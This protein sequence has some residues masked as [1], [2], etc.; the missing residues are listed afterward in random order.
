MAPPAQDLGHQAA[1]GRAGRLRPAD[2]P[3]RRPLGMGPVRAGHVLREGR[4]LATSGQPTV[5]GHSFGFEVD[6]DD[7]RAEARLE[8]FT[9]QLVGH[10]VVVLGDLDVVVDRDPARLPL[11]Q[12]VALRRQGLQ[13]RPIELLVE[14]AAAGAE[15]LHRPAVELTQ[16][17]PDRLVEL[18]EAEKRLIAQGGQDPALGHQD[19]G[20]H[21]RLVAGLAHPGRDDHRP[22][23]RGQLLVGAIDLGL[24]AARCRDAA[25]EIVRHIDRRRAVEKL[26][27]PRVRGDPVRKLLARG[28]L[29]IGVAR[30]PQHPDK[31][32]H[33][34]LL[35]GAPV[36]QVRLLARVVDKR[37]LAGPVPLAHR[38]IELLGPAPVDLAELAV[39]IARRVG[40]QVL[41]P[42]QVQGHALAL[43]LTMDV[44]RVGLR[45]RTG[46]RARAAQ[47]LRLQRRLVQCLG[48]WPAQAGFPRPLQVQRHRA[49]THRARPG[50]RPVRQPHLPLQPQNL[51]N[52]PHR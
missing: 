15:A 3:R 7:R 32:L 5:G 2:Q 34:D 52:L 12:L 49:Q 31:Q 1:G 29:G 14:L 25:L 21:L 41:D 10:A 40:L 43:E 44:R 19:G 6:L 8:Q 42:Q 36:D 9:D 33:R 23:V 45:P 22:V 39:A 30:R 24:V 11:G 50:N 48:Q 17:L 28:R 37:L 20:L 26:Q 38:R 13:G 16:L 51:S 35:A 27:H 47:N 18:D 4:G 46:R